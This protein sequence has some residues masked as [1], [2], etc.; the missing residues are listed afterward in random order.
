[1]IE[2]GMYH[3]TMREIQDLRD[4]LMAVHDH[5]PEDGDDT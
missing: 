1:M 2:A 5:P 3:Y 4:R